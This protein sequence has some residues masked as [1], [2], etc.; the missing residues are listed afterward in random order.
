MPLRQAG[1]SAQGSGATLNDDIQHALVLLE[2]TMLLFNL[3]TIG[4][5]GIK[6]SDKEKNN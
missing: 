6:K 2:R 1:M 3:R 4:N 5:N